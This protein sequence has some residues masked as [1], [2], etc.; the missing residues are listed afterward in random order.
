VWI[1]QRIEHNEEDLAAGFLGEDDVRSLFFAAKLME[2]DEEKTFALL[3]KS[4][5]MGHAY[6]QSELG[7]CYYNGEVR[8]KKGKKNVKNL[9]SF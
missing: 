7:D 2:F 8:K 9:N 4:A 6:A 5:E 3:E 1:L